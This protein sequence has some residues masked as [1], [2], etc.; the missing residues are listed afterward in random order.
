MVPA[1]DK[2]IV[3]APAKINLFLEVVGERD[4]GYHD[5]R[6]VVA[7]L[8]L[9][10]TITLERTD[11]VLEI[12]MDCSELGC[13]DCNNDCG[14][15]DAIPDNENIAYKAALLLRE[16]TG[17]SFGARIQIQKRIPIG[18]GLGGLSKF[19]LLVV[20]VGIE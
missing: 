15:Y 13:S 9:S 7:P 18:G 1:I 12:S 19:T 6:S 20:Q 10:D 11:G 14:W 2:T 16:K 4:D 17:V 8:S 5:L 3:E